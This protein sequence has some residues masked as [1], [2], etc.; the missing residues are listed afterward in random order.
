MMKSS[1]KQG[2][3]VV[4][5][6]MPCKFWGVTLVGDTAQEPTLTLYDNATTNSGTVIAFLMVSDESHS[7]KVMLPKPIRCASGIY[8]ALS[9]ETGDFVVYYEEG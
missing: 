3:S 8:G 9:E 1:S 5:S 4:I 6:A 2:A 7:A